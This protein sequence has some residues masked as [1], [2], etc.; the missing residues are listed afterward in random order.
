MRLKPIQKGGGGGTSGYSGFSGYS[1]GGSTIPVTN[2]IHVDNKRID[3]YVADG[4]ISKPFITIQAAINSISGSS[5]TNKF[6]INIAQGAFYPENITINK[7]FIIFVGEKFTRLTGDITLLDPASRIKFARLQL[8][9]NFTAILPGESI[10]IDLEDCD[11]VSGKT[12]T[13][14]ATN[15]SDYVYFSQNFQVYGGNWMANL[16]ATNVTV[17]FYESGAK[18]YCTLDITGGPS[19][20]SFY[21]DGGMFEAIIINLTNVARS[22]I[23]A[24]TT[25]NEG[26][27]TVA[28]NLFGT[29][30]LTADACFLGGAT[31]TNSGTGTITLLT[32]SADIKNDSSVS[33]TSVKDAMNTLQK[34]IVLMNPQVGTS[35]LLSLTDAGK[36]VTLT[37]GSPIAVT[38]PTNTL[39]PFLVG[40]VIDF[41]QGGVGKVTFSGAGVTIKSKASNLSI[42]AQN[43]KVS[44]I[45]EATNTWYLTGDL[46]P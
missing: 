8:R 4:S 14:T 26:D 35:Y 37:N 11:A 39:V 28:V 41:I 33:G 36:T 45:K 23:S 27:E 24:V 1:G 18:Y 9:G 46:I 32:K 38:V 22:F 13:I 20:R 3:L 17:A 7:D 34:N 6:Q 21:C 30:N 12:W 19:G 2:V 44:L 31:V 15:P 16:V 29:T 40:T 10:V 42:A 5:S 43:V 25:M